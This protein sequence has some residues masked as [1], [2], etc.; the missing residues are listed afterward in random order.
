MKELEITSNTETHIQ[1]T[2]LGITLEVTSFEYWRD[3]LIKRGSEQAHE[4]TASLV[5][6]I[7][8]DKHQFLLCERKG[9]RQEIKPYK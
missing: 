6:A 2:V 3:T 1:T 5:P 4:E 8:V 9:R 7:P